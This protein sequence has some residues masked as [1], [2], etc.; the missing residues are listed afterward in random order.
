[1]RLVFPNAHRV[2]RGTYVMGEIAAACR[3]NAI[4]DLLIIHE[5]RGVPDALVV[6]HFPHGPTVLFT[7]H[8]VVLRHD[9]PSGSTSTVSEQYPHLILD[10]FGTKLGQRIGSVLKHL[11]PVPKEDSKR[12]MTFANQSDFISFRLVL[13]ILVAKLSRDVQLISF[14][15]CSSGITYLSKRLIK[16]FN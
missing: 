1:M 11:F 8:N 3:A 13:L 10:G 5:H 14:L 9:V 16:R 7:L 6:S 15:E 12:V 4:T 2:N